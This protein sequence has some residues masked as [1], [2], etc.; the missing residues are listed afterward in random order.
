MRIVLGPFRMA[1]FKRAILKAIL[2][3]LIAFLPG[4]CFLHLLRGYAPGTIGPD[5]NPLRVL[6]EK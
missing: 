6:I 5:G 1:L 2:A 3:G 4:M